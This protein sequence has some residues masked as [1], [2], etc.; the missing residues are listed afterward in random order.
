MKIY[1]IIKMDYSNYRQYAPYDIVAF[2]EMC[3]MVDR[4]KRVFRL[5]E[6]YVVPH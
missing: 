2:W 6:T 1:N 4:S 3:E 5:V